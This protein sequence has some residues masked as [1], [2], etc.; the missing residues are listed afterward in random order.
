MDEVNPTLLG[1]TSSSLA[2]ENASGFVYTI[3][4]NTENVLFNTKSLIS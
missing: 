4:W 2:H 1:F 3:H